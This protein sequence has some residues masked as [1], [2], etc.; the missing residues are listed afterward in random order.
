MIRQIRLPLLLL[1]MICSAAAQQP[2]TEVSGPAPYDSTNVIVSPE[3]GKKIVCNQLQVIFKDGVKQDQRRNAVNTING[4]IAGYLDD[5]DIYQITV[6]NRKCEFSSLK[7]TLEKL[8]KHR[9]VSQVS[10]RVVE[11]RS[12]EKIDVGKLRPQ[13][14]GQLDMQPAERKK[15]EQP[16]EMDLILENN[17]KTLY[18]CIEQFPG[19]HG[20]TEIR[21]IISPEGGIKQ[22][23]LLKTNVKNKKITDCMKFRIGKWNDFPPET[24]GF[25]RNLEFSFKF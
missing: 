19:S 4:T 22:V 21:I 5:L 18:T 6:P 10:Y 20:E 11:E 1:G 3:T 2:K 16:S 14:H 25:D 12:F 7:Q 24:K 13:R 8:G 15:K 23:T 9:S 17:K